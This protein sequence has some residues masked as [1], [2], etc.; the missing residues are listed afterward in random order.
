MHR[1]V[2]LAFLMLASVAQ[3]DTLEQAQALYVRGQFAGAVRVALEVGTARAYAL[4][5]MANGALAL[6]APQAQRDAIYQESERLARVAI[7]LDPKEPE[8]HFELAR[9]LGRLI[10]LRGSLEA[11][12]RGW[13]GEMQDS[14]EVCLR[15]QPR[16]AGAMVALALWHVEL[17][18]SGAGWMYGA[19]VSKVESLFREAVRLE[20]QAI[21]V[22]LEYAL[23]LLKLDATRNRARAVDLLQEATRLPPRDAV[24]RLELERAR[25]E[26]SILTR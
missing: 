12:L 2:L 6:T 20:P 9:A 21:V 23:A 1:I 11:V 8:G 22:R 4:A 5:A 17:H 18:L 24:E 19:D 14:L 25:R 3:A 16:H 26:L 13:L 10:Q 15:L 7:R